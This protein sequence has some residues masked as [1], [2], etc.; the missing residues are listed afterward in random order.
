MLSLRAAAD[1]GAQALRDDASDLLGDIG[2]GAPQTAELPSEHDDEPHRGSSHDRGG[3]PRGLQKSD[4]AKE[5]ARP[6]LGYRFPLVEDPC[7]PLFDDEELVGEVSLP[8][9]RG[10]STDFDLVRPLGYLPKVG[11]RQVGDGE[12]FLRFAASIGG[13][14]PERPAQA[15]RLKQ[16][17]PDETIDDIREG[18]VGPQAESGLDEARR[19]AERH[20]WKEA[21]ELFSSPDVARDLTPADL[22]AMAESAWWLGRVDDAIRWREQAYAAYLEQSQ[23]ES[24]ARL[25]IDIAWDHFVQLAGPVGMGWVRRAEALVEDRPESPAHGHLTRVK[26]VLA[27]EVEGSYQQAL[28]LARE[29]WTTG[30][31][32]GDRDLE[33]LGLHDQGRILVAMGRVEEGMALMD[34]AMVAAVGGELGPMATGKIYCNM[35]SICEKLADYGRAADWTEAAKRWCD[36]EGHDSGFPGLCRVHR[37][38]IMRLRGSWEEAEREARQACTEL[39]HFLNY[40]GEA[41]YEIGEIRL[42]MGDRI[43]AEEA[44]RQAH[45]L[46]RKPVP[47]LAQLRLAQGRS[48]AAHALIQEALADGGL[49]PLDQARLLPAR[50]EIALE[51]G[52]LDEA[53]GAADRLEQIATEY[54]S[55]AFRAAAAQARGH[56]WLEEGDPEAAITTLREACRLWQEVDLPYEAAQTR[57]LLGLAYGAEGNEELADLELRAARST[58]QRLGA[59]PDVLKVDELLGTGKPVAK[60]SRTLMFTDIVGSTDLIGVIGDDAWEHLVRWHDETLRS[61]F[62]RHGG[63]EID[64]AGD[65]FFVSFDEAQAAVDCAVAIQQSLEE[66]RRTQGFAPS[67]RIGLHEA[68]VGPAPKGRGVHEAARI[69]GAARGGEILLSRTTA[70][71]IRRSDLAEYRP[72]QLKGIGE[73]IEVTTFRWR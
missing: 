41:F 6:Q 37:A 67:V 21:Y 46:G 72:L 8:N 27:F 55:T 20:A 48:D 61:L 30:R 38:E 43:G 33:A 10:T 70:E 39:Q 42:R 16:T 34:E 11:L 29:V 45:E 5:V 31:R 32:L 36:R 3:S 52:D 60:Q 4:L 49:G 50:V 66:H 68:N 26:A 58:F 64:H 12:T 57:L 14:S 15:R 1:S 22:E 9:Q 56:L 51:H 13:F 53:R 44:F 54:G 73:P 62:A 28:E 69:A 2:K 23:P 7:G 24:A 47:G 65:G 40:T 71:A 59:S 63:T 25:A 18:T 35:I 19:A 17:E